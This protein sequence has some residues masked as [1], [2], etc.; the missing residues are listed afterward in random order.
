MALNRPKTSNPTAAQSAQFLNSNNKF[1]N[2]KD[3]QT[4]LLRFLPPPGDAP[5]IFFPVTN[6]HGMKKDDGVGKAAL[7]CLQNHGVATTGR[8]CLVCDVLNYLKE[9]DEDLFDEVKKDSA[10]RTRYY[11]Q[12]LNAQMGKDERNKPIVLGWSRPVLIQ[13]SKTAQEDLQF[14]LDK[15][16]ENGDDRFF[17]IESGQ[18]IYVSRKGGGLDTKYTPERSSVKVSLDTIRPTWGDEFIEDIYKTVGLTIF[19]RDVQLQYMQRSY[20]K[21]PWQEILAALGIED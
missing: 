18:G 8:K 12:V 1:F 20:P 16:D 13:W 4:A 14:I 19:D 17:D 3:G 9:T 21:L 2:I 5:S 6:H 7:A 11:T 10:A 15:M